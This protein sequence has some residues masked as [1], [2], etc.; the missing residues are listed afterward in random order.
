M[1]HLPFIAP[2]DFVA[3]KLLM[4]D[5]I[6]ATYADWEQAHQQQITDCYRQALA[7]TEVVVTPAEFAAYCRAN[8]AEP[9]AIVLRRF[10][11]EKSTKRR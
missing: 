3:F 6:P 8:G 9:K 5:Q 11:R 1:I 4:K 10:A 7:H 2:A